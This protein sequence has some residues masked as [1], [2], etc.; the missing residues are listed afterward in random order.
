MAAHS[1]R[2]LGR[3]KKMRHLHRNDKLQ[4]RLRFQSDREAHSA[5]A[6]LHRLLADRDRPGLTVGQMVNVAATMGLLE[7]RKRSFR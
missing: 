7:Q 5:M 1:P 2:N 6:D 3:E 4:Q